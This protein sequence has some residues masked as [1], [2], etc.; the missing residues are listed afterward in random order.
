MDIYLTDTTTKERI[1]IPL[2]PDT[3]AIGGK[4]EFA[5]YTVLSRGEVKLPS[6]TAL[7]TISW[8]AMFPGAARRGMR[9][10]REWAEPKTLIAWLDN[11]VLARHKLRLLITDTPVNLDVYIEQFSGNYSGGYGDYEYSI[12]FVQARGVSLTTVPPKS[13]GSNSTAP[14]G[15]NRAAASAPKSYTVKK[16]DSLWRIAQQQLGAGA[17]WPEIYD[18]NK[19]KIKNPN[20]IYAGQA[21]IL[22]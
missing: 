12:D 18:L 21:F 8:S 6:G 11:A 5:S 3:I 7:T 9:F 10:V 15:G 4:T 13:A 14:A 16:G 1:R 22:P 19:D 2:L 20:L 17:R